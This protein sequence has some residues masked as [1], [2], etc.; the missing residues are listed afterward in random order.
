MNKS[1]STLSSPEFINIHSVSPMI[2]KCE[3]KVLYVGQ[4]R[5]RSSISKEVAEQ[6]AQTL[7]GC[8]IVGY[9]IENKEDFGDHGD[10]MIIDGEGVHFKK[11]TKPY[12]FVPLDAKVW[13]QDFED[14]D[15]FGKPSFLMILTG[16]DYSYKREDGI[17]VV[18][19]GNFK[20]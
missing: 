9:Y 14:I 18:S 5:N 2:S 19:I 17:Y 12:G 8:P 7:P 1:I 11:L 20:N 15:K 6:M 16:A 13:F 3:I 4:N 10:Q